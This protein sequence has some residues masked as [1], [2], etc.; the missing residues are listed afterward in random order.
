MVHR[1]Q[2]YYLLDTSICIDFLRGNKTALHH[3]IKEDGNCFLSVI[4]KIELLMGA[5]NAPEP[6]FLTELHKVQTFI[7]RYDTIGF[8]DSMHRFCAEKIRLQRAGLLIEDFDLLIAT[9]AI[10]NNMVVVTS[11]KKH[12]DRVEGIKMEDWS[13]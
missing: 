4:T 8:D 5:Y 2:Q 13:Q 7:D 12:F 11:N 9:T 6:Y 10:T 1:I 3:F